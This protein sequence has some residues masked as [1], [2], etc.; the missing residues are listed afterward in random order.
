MAGD[1]VRREASRRAV[2]ARNDQRAAIVAQAKERGGLR[3][4]EEAAVL[5]GV[6]PASVRYYVKRGLLRPVRVVAVGLERLL[7]DDSEII[8]FRR[9]WITSGGE[10]RWRWLDPDWYVEI[11]RA[12][13]I[14]ERAA[15]E[16]GLSL[17]DMD[18]VY[19]A[20]ADRRARWF[21]LARRGRR[22]RTVPPE[23]HLEWAAQFEFLTERFLTEYERSR[24][25]T[26]RSR[27]ATSFDTANAGRT[28]P[29]TAMDILLGDGRSPR[30]I[31][32]R[33]RFAPS[34][35][36]PCKSQRLKIAT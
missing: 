15:R 13:G 14:T 32:S 6:T 12:R 16:K 20:R 21:R 25:S 10:Q 28:T 35:Q 5:L 7:F 19:R 11:H 17:E 4:T 8:L 3:T 33:R 31:A 29:T 36:S 22:S 26:S 23:H 30:S 2:T 24:R 9:E 18:A 34:M 1:V 27:M